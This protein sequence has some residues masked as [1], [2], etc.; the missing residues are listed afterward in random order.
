MSDRVW[1]ISEVSG[2]AARHACEESTL[3]TR[4][5]DGCIYVT[6]GTSQRRAESRAS[7]PRPRLAAAVQ[8]TARSSRAVG[9]G[10]C[11]ITTTGLSL[12]AT[13][14]AVE[15]AGSGA[16]ERSEESIY[17]QAVAQFNSASEA[18]R[19]SAGIVAQRSSQSGLADTVSERA[20]A[21]LSRSPLRAALCSWNIAS[22]VCCQRSWLRSTRHWFPTNAG[23]LEEC[24]RKGRSSAWR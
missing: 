18:V 11:D 8:A 19:D 7:Q 3:L 13:S 15:K 14:A 6:Y 17:R 22:I 2:E 5:I 10:V 9:P 23:P 20:R 12:S 4:D 16:G 21:W 1:H 24:F